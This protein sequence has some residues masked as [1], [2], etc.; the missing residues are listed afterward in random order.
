MGRGIERR[1][2]GRHGSGS[3]DAEN[4]ATVNQAGAEPDEREE[5]S[6]GL[7]PPRRHFLEIRA[8]RDLCFLFPLPTEGNEEPSVFPNTLQESAVEAGRITPG[9]LV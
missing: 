9:F 2:R 8:G 3:V 5:V 7:P 1:G 4:T 6:Y